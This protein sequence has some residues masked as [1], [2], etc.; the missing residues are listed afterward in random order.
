MEFPSGLS[1]EQFSFQTKPLSS[2][3][4]LEGVNCAFC[5]EDAV[6]VVFLETGRELCH[7]TDSLKGSPGVQVQFG[8]YKQDYKPLQKLT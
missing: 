4:L 2:F 3:L 5:Q 1:K 7:P 8:S 6:S